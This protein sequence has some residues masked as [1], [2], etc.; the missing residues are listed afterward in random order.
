M[1][2]VIGLLS[3]SYENQQSSGISG[4][5]RRIKARLALLLETVLVRRASVLFTAGDALRARIGRGTVFN[6]SLVR[7]NEVRGRLD[8][9]SGERIRW[10]YVGRVD[11]EKGSDILFE[12][13]AS[14]YATD[15]SHELVVV[16]A[17]AAE[18]SARA[19]ID[20]LGIAKV[21]R[22]RGPCS[23]QEVQAELRSAD[24]FVF[25]SRHEG[26]PKA[27]LEAMACGL[28][29]VAARSGAE[30]YVTH[31]ENGLLVPVGDVAAIGASVRRIVA[32]RELRQRLIAGAI[33]TALAN[34]LEEHG[35]NTQREICKHFPLLTDPAKADWVE[36][37]GRGV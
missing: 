25:P 28:P 32:D 37:T 7:R 36:A 21:T 1:V 27:P 29:V 3:A 24:V 30:A 19:L 17:V 22:L 23:R 11:F 12:A 8:S 31:E 15:P 26:M 6:T 34:C 10:L 4:V 14:V 2:I 13:F 20:R 35:L 9:C 16:G 5:A 18:L 33:A